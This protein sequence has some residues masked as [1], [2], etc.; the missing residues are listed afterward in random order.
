MGKDENVGEMSQRLALGTVIGEASMGAGQTQGPPHPGP[1]GLL[2]M[3]VCLG[4]TPGTFIHDSSTKEVLQPLIQAGG[5]PILLTR[6]R[7]WHL[8]GGKSCRNSHR[9][10]GAPLPSIQGFPLWT[11][12]G[13]SWPHGNL[14]FSLPGHFLNLVLGSVPH[15]CLAHRFPICD[16]V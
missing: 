7:Y 4:A 13:L 16:K 8:L 15:Q 12:T 1:R 6:P 5:H 3:G 9:G 10:Q 2:K 11:W 14:D